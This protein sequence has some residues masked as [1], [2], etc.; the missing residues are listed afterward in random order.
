MIF[1]RT[2]GTD[3]VRLRQ[4]KTYHTDLAVTSLC[5]AGNGIGFMT[6]KYAQTQS[7]KAVNKIH[8]FMITSMTHLA[9]VTVN[10][11]LDRG[12]RLNSSLACQ[13]LQNF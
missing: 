8:S 3:N 11:G 7:Q 10:K 12:P 1:M 4:V 2:V 13:L 5:M 9:R 6:H